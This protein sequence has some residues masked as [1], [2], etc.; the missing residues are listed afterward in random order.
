MNAE[1][2][3]K[4][5]N[6]V[7]LFENERFF[8]SSALTKGV[9]FPQYLIENYIQL[10]GKDFEDPVV[11]EYQ[12]LYPHLK[13]VPTPTFHTVSFDMGFENGV[14]SVEE[15]TAMVLQHG[16]ALGSAYGEEKATSGTIVVPAFFKQKVSIK[17][18]KKKKI[19]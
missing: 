6:A 10:L 8:G 4:T 14:Y 9:R 2:K 3:R 13:L 12:K 15:V 17:C 5:S 18:E 11:A 19:G 7:A 16:M 1:S